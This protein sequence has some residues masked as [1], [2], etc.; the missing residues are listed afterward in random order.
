MRP[1]PRATIILQWSI[2]A[3][4]E[5]L[6]EP[7][8]TRIDI[9]P[10]DL[11]LKTFLV[12]LASG[13]RVSELAALDRASVRWEDDLTGVTIPDRQGF[14]FK[15]QSLDRVPPGVYFFCSQRAKGIVSGG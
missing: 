10:E 2:S 15:N 14:V 1:P 6:E 9:A 8:F 7:R 4:L 12:A 5:S 13:N 3:I 11:F